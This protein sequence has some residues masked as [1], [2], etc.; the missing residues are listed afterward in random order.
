ML[1]YHDLSEEQ[2]QQLLNEKSKVMLFFTATWCGDCRFIKPQMPAI[3]A[4]FHDY[5]FVEIDRDEE[6]DLAEKFD[7]MGIPSFVALNAGEEV[8]RFVNKDR[9][10]KAQ[11]ETFIEGLPKL[12]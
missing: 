6:L 10:T 12:N 5:T 2:R 7:I 9:K 1:S 4:D 8:G 3:E 11:V